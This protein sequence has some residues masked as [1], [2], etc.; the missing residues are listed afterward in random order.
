LKL[1]PL[2]SF[3]ITRWPFNARRSG[4]TK[5]RSSSLYDSRP[6]GCTSL[7]LSR[8]CNPRVRLALGVAL[9]VEQARFER[10]A[11]WCES[12]TC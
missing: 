12:H 5:I 2:S 9:G 6:P 1:A 10:L 3:A 7:G 11:P 8:L 4:S